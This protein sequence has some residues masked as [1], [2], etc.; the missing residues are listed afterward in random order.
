MCGRYG[1]YKN[2]EFGE[3]FG[4]DLGDID[5][6][7]NYNVAPGQ[8]MPVILDR[9]EGKV[10]ELLRWGLVPVWAK[11]IKIGYKLINA[12]S[13]TLYEKSMWKSLIKSKRCLVPA[14]GFYEWKK[15]ATEP[16]KKQP[17]FIHPQEKKLFAFAGLWSS[18][19]DVEG[20]EWNTYTIITTE[21]N[22]EMRNIHDR[23]PVILSQSDESAWL[24]HD[25]DNDRGAIEALLRPYHDGGL[26][27]FE[28][29]SDV[30]VTKNNDQHLIYPI[31][32]Q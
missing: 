11:D 26:T 12:R 15:D 17:F 9:G 23:M 28:V 3:R 24:S 1:F 27:M 19:K 5:L 16:K 22:K 20:M 25:N 6:S 7:D 18:W 14:N 31:N 30:N 2:D 32:S 10:L 21:P 29:S 4:V 13:E 8:T